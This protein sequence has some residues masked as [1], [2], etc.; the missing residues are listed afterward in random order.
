MIKISQN[1]LVPL[2]FNIKNYEKP[3]NSSIFI[4]LKT[5]LL[6]HDSLLNFAQ[7]DRS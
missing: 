4:N 7:L 2:F 6:S 1:N 3:L 5:A